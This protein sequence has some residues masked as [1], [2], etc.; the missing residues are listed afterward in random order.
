MAWK[1]GLFVFDRADI[2]DVMRQLA[3]WYDLDVH[4]TGEVPKGT[5]KGEISKDLSLSQVLNGLTATRIHFTMESG[6]RIT[7][8][9]E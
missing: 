3:R 9:P 7:I 5:F 2:R 6:N 1:N 4:Y 8:L